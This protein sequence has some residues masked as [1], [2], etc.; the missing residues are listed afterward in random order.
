MA[1]YLQG[2]LDTSR[3][4]S[5][6]MGVRRLSKL[7][8]KYYPGATGGDVDGGERSGRISGMFSKVMHRKGDRKKGG[9]S[10]NAESYD[11]VTPFRLDS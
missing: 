10:A 8:D 5:D 7:V 1:M 6:T 3:K 4:A 2:I 9:A 11:L